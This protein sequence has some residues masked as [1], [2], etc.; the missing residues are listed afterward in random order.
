MYLSIK[1]LIEINDVKEAN[2]YLEKGWKLITI[3]KGNYILG[4]PYNLKT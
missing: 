3:E 2:L 4:R 1:E